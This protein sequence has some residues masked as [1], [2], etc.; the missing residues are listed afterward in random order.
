MEPVKENPKQSSYHPRNVP[1]KVKHELRDKYYK[2][3]NRRAKASSIS[4]PPSTST[5]MNSSPPPST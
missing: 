5:S 4:I 3:Q 2:Q 1:E